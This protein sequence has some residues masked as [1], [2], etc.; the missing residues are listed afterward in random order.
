[1]NKKIAAY[2]EI[3]M[4]LTVPD[5]LLLRQ[6]DRLNYSFTGTV[7]NVTGFMAQF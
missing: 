6:A 3:M 5:H 2:G 4:R 1:M 7:V